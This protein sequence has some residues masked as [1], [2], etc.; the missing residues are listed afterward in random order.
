MKFS[1]IA[2]CVVLAGTGDAFA[3]SPKTPSKIRPTELR[4]H[5]NDWLPAASAAVAGWAVAAQLAFASPATVQPVFPGEYEQSMVI[6][7]RKRSTAAV[8]RTRV[9]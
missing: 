8:V 1:A 2:L 9:I 3:P 5:R 7:S 6:P 4:A